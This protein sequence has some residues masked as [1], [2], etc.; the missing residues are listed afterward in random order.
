MKQINKLLSLLI[1]LVILAGS[2][3]L[4]AAA[5]DWEYTFYGTVGKTEYFIITSNAYDEILEATI[6][7]GTIPYGMELNIAGDVT[8]GLAGVPTTDGEFNAFITMKTRDLGTVDIK[9]TV[10]I[11]P[12]DPSSE[13]VPVVTKNPTKETVVEGESATFIARANNVRQYIWEIGMGDA[14]MTCQE[15]IDYYGKGIKITGYDTEKLVIHNVPK[16]LD[17]VHVWCQF[18]G[19]E[20][21]E[22]SDAAMLTVIAQKDAT[23]VVTK[24]PSDETVE[25]GG[26]AVLIAKAKY[27]QSYLWQFVSPDG[28]IY[29]C[30]DAP[31]SFKG[32][33][34][35][36]ADSERI[37]LKNIPLELNG[38]RIRCKFTAGEVVFSNTAKLTV[39]EKPT[40]PT[41]EPPTE[42]PTEPPTEAPTEAPTEQPAEEPAATQT[43]KKPV[44]SKNDAQKDAG[45]GGGN[46]ALIITIIISATTIVVAGIAAFVILKLKSGGK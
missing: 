26:E 7:S 6:Y 3:A 29:D 12:A 16:D 20:D 33:T 32:L 5:A 22:F 11:N 28:A 2:L 37:V 35:S 38:Y 24:S 17:G 40:E 18:V 21:S 14:T 42:A 1:I 4:P 43:G 44:T 30:A 23:P 13:G 10:Y 36:G 31:K 41:T 39:T 46:T 8:L 45:S 15:F 34:V 25:E 27:A 9:V 19:A